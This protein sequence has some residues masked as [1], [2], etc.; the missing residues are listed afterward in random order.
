MYII[1][2]LPSGNLTWQWKINTFNRYFLMNH[3][4]IQANLQ[5]YI[6]QPEGMTS[7]WWR[8]SW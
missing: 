2:V 4:E 7:M 5:T 6:A 8:T 1:C 3:V